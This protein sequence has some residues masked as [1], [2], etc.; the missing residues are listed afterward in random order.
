M[1]HLELTPTFQRLRAHVS[2]ELLRP[3]I[4]TFALHEVGGAVKVGGGI[5]R[6]GDAVVLPK[7]SLIRAYG[8]TDAAVCA[9]VIVMSWGALDCTSQ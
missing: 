9:G 2:E 3:D 4:R 6:A 1:N 5:S 8:A 7:L